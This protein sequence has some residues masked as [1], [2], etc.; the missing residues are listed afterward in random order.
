MIMLIETP[1]NYSDNATRFRPISLP[2]TDSKVLENLLI[3][4]IMY[5]VHSQQLLNPNHY[6]FSQKKKYC[7]RFDDS[8]EV[9]GAEFL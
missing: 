4:W 2:Y 9:R 8:E 1:G 7:G 3:Y 5:H 6:G